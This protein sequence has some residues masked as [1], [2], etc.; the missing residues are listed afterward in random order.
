MSLNCLSHAFVQSLKGSIAENLENY[1]DENDWVV[2]LASL[3]G[4]IRDTGLKIADPP[5]L[6]LP[7]QG[8][9]HETENVRRLHSAFRE[10]TPLQ[11]MDER[12]WTF[13]SHFPYWDYMQV[14][15]VK[16]TAGT[17]RDRYFFDGAGFGILV[18]NGISRLWWFGH[19]TWDPKRS[20]PYEMTEVLLCNQDV[21][22]ALLQ[23]SFGKSRHVLLA[24]LEHIRMHRDTLYGDAVGTRIKNKA[25][26]LNVLGG[27]SL[28][29]AL[30]TQSIHDFLSAEE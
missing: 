13:L 15:W 12:L 4:H 29:D 10:L 20:D 1:S 5:D 8:E 17:V 9:F 22:Q 25:K 21:Q 28:L 11:A 27:V 16:K 6:L 30:R 2:S 26:L 7:D 24:V 23:R 19:L 14:R 3:G 18:R